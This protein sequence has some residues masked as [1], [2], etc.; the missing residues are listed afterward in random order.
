M[1]ENL[2]NLETAVQGFLATGNPPTPEGIRKLINQF[3]IIESCAVTDAEA[4]Q[5][6]RKFE[7]QH[8]VTMTVGAVLTE[9]GYEPWLEATR[10]KITPYYWGRY[11]KLLTQK[12]Y[13]GQVI[14][15]MDD[16]TDRILGLLEN[17][18]KD[19]PW[20]RRGMVVGHVQ[21]GKTA[22]YTGLLCKAADAGYKIIIVIAGIHNNLRNQTQMRIDEGFVGRDSAKR[23]SGRD[24]H[25]GVGLFDRTHQ[26]WTF[27]TSTRDFNKLGANQVGGKLSDLSVP[28][29]FVIKKNGST[30]K[31]LLEWLR[32][33]NARGETVD[34]PMLVIDDEADNASIN[35]KHDNDEISRINGQI[36]NL[37]RMFE[38]S[39][40]IGYTATPFANIFIDPDTDDA[41]KGEDLF[42][43]SFIVSLDAPSNY[44]GPRRVFIE[45]V[46][47]IV[48]TIDDNEDVL[49]LKHTKEF[50]VIGLPSSLMEAIR[51][52]VVARAI[53]LVR[54]QVNQHASMLVNASRFTD[55]Q[56]QLRNE[57]HQRLERIQASCRVYGALPATQALKDPELHALQAVWQK[58]YANCGT[59]WDD[60]QKLLHDAAAPIRTV[61]VNSRSSGT[62]NYA[63]HEKSGLAVIA[64]GGFSLSRGLTLE[65]LTVSYFLRNSMMY[66][67][68]MQMGR[69]FGYRPDY[70]D[71]CR[72]WMPDEAIGWYQHVTESIEELREE[73][74][75]M[76]AANA[77]P[78]EFGL[79]VRSHPDTL[80]VTAR[81]KMG[82][83]EQVVVS[84]GLANRF[85]ETTV[86]KADTDSLDTNRRAAQ[87][88]SK[89][90]AKLGKPLSVA[91]PVSTGFLVTDVP[92]EPILE[93]LSAFQNQPR[94]MFTMPGPVRSFIEKRQHDE[95]TAW[96]VLFPSISRADHV[97]LVDDSLGV[98]I[99]CQRRKRGKR[100]TDTILYVTDNQ[101]VASRGVEKTGV[102]PEHAE[103]AEKA[104][105]Q[106]TDYRIGSTNYP[107]AIYREVR[108]KPLLIVH[109]L[110]I[111]EANDDLSAQKPSIAW[112]VSFPRTK[113]DEQRVEYIVNTT[114]LRENYH[115]DLAEEEMRGDGE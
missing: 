18:A 19:G 63:D 66:D 62:L 67:T 30:L 1:S 104:F 71:L 74:R 87:E 21:S 57:I 112:S 88:L 76:E 106:T 15:A 27:T 11:K 105:Q 16:V 72:I 111:G 41:M 100:S 52:F 17:P 4:E 93:F 91:K 81:N 61:E 50:E 108:T 73:M 44:F 36:R 115:E 42:P 58:H 109:L 32:E 99:T 97:P 25:I 43:R 49:P 13:S 83:G 79:K 80:I 48:R 103:E 5:L 10:P 92:V 69:W 56:R 75:L 77:T 102:D 98:S 38:R 34:A 3:R 110:S 78:E 14:A 94:S 33:Y 53:R 26:P 31:N 68:L 113:T 7:N 23:T 59:S 46:D 37:L 65:G 86:L 101:R 12:R 29:V 85:I 39:C 40:Y 20:D 47:S 89:R 55:V 64:V 8:G 22:N 114:W 70:E 82:S 107:D 60:V 2:I 45:D 54:G 90:L 95:L 51:A 24:N 35:I 28:A 84:I 9:K 6:A 96:D